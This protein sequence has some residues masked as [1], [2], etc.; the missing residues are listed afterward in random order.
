MALA[1]VATGN[2][3]FVD[4]LA[5]AAIALVGLSVAR[6]APVWAF[7]RLRFAV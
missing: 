7:P 1:V 3:F 6:R 2:H 4:A 5:G